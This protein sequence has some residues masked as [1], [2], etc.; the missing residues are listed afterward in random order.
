MRCTGTI[1][2]QHNYNSQKLKNKGA[3]FVNETQK[4]YPAIAIEFLI[5]VFIN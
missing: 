1:G 4:S 5:R 3:W 2:L